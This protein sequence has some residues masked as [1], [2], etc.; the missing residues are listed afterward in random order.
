M[1]EEETI[2]AAI[3]GEF[4]SEVARLASR[5]A[6]EH[7]ARFVTESAARIREAVEAQ[8][9]DPVAVELVRLGL[10][11]IEPGHWVRQPVP[12]ITKQQA[13]D[14]LNLPIPEGKSPA[15]RLSMVETLLNGLPVETSPSTPLTDFERERHKLTML[16]PP[17]DNVEQDDQVL[18]AD[19]KAGR[20]GARLARSIELGNLPVSQV[21]FAVEQMTR[22]G[23]SQ[24]EM[25]SE[26][27]T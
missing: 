25:P 16:R 17:D 26:D 2:D 19:A 12:L 27:P 4:G 22:P 20:Y 10:I 8:K 23:R 9:P 1:T 21:R 11:E 3:A 6:E 13:I 15:D 5:L 24:A 14:L 7:R 18:M